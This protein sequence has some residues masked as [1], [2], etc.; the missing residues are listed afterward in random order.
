MR[1]IMLIMLGLTLALPAH[2]AE[3]QVADLGRLYRERHCLEAAATTFRSLLGEARVGPIY[4]SGWVTHADGIN[5]QHDAVITCAHGN[6]GSTRA[7]LV[8]HSTGRRVDAYWVAQRIAQIFDR[9][10]RQITQAWKDSYD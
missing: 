4:T 10:A 2:A 8:L 6:G 5:G 9:R 1:R 3:W 7:T